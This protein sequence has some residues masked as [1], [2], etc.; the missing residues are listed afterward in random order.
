MSDYIK[1]YKKYKQKYLGL[2]V[3]SKSVL[4]KKGGGGG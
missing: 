1:K 2:D 4:D 3:S